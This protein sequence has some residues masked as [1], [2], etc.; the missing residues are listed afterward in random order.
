VA[1]LT[2]FD[3]FDEQL[4]SSGIDVSGWKEEEDIVV[5]AELLTTEPLDTEAVAFPESRGRIVVLV[6][7]VLCA[8]IGQ[9]LDVYMAAFIPPLGSTIRPGIGLSPCD[10]F[11][12]RPAFCIDD[13]KYV[14]NSN[15]E[16]V[17]TIMEDHV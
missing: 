14:V 12:F 13:D 11:S 1:S 4:R 9:L 15:K 2:R 17:G 5:P 16:I 10:S 7:V 6:A 3:S 8:L